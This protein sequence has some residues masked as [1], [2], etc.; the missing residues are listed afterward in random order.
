[1][2]G[3][4]A[5]GEKE[6]NPIPANATSGGKPEKSRSRKSAKAKTDGKGGDLGRLKSRT[7]DQAQADLKASEA[8]A[9]EEQKRVKNRAKNALKNGTE[10][11]AAAQKSRS[12]EKEDASIKS[13]KA[14]TV[15]PQPSRRSSRAAKG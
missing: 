5:Q 2:A 3:T 4:V 10:N 15:R 14:S 7:S 13:E 12:Q 6:N 11:G 9:R 8:P 1:M